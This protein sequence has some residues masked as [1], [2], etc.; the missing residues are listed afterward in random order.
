MAAIQPEN[1]CSNFGLCHFIKKEYLSFFLDGNLSLAHFSF[2]KKADYDPSG[3]L[4]FD[5]GIISMSSPGK[6]RFFIGEEKVYGQPAPIEECEEVPLAG[7]LKFWAAENTK[8]H[9]FSTTALIES[10]GEYK[11]DSR[12][13]IDRDFMIV[14]SKPKEFLERFDNAIMNMG[15][16]GSRG[17]VE[18]LDID[19]RRTKEIFFS[20]TLAYAYQKE[21]RIAVYG[22]NSLDR[23]SLQ[24][25]DLRRMVRVIDLN[26]GVEI[27]V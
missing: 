24:V 26:L 18:Y 2:Y 1:E 6:T 8:C 9:I 22:H 19:D 13:K 5:E 14:F 12:L 20:K 23:L 16:A 4:D 25:G 10:N 7:T 11:F 27:E 17:F 15:L 21:V 3:R